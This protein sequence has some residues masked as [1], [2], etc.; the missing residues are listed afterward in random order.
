MGSSLILLVVRS[1][2]S[3][4]ITL[5]DEIVKEIKEN[6]FRRNKRKVDVQEGI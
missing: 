1:L 6:L 2:E 3:R 5:L 4:K